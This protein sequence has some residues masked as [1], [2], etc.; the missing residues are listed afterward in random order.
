MVRRSYNSRQDDSLRGMAE[1][2]NALVLKT[3][4]DNTPVGSNP[5][6]PARRKPRD[7]PSSVDQRKQDHRCA[8][9]HGLGEVEESAHAA[10]T[11]AGEAPLYRRAKKT[12]A[13][14][15]PESNREPTNVEPAIFGI[16]PTR[17]SGQQEK[18]TSKADRI[19][20]EE[21]VLDPHPA[22]CPYRFGPVNK[23]NRTRPVKCRFNECRSHKGG[24]K[25]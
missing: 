1:R 10:A 7:V 13:P 21:T 14:K 18:G 9:R 16:R 3:S 15:D 6:A 25:R 20:R 24:E 11:A 5:T 2:T 23:A 8:H 19:E 17:T 4:G 12:E 22:P